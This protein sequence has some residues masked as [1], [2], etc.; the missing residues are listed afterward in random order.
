MITEQSLWEALE[1][2]MDPEIPTISMVDMG[3]L[4]QD[5]FDA[6]KAD[7]LSQM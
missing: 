7:I 4:T 2:V 6:K 5:E 3:I 1:S